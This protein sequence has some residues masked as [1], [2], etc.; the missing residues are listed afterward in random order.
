MTTRRWLVILLFVIVACFLADMIWIGS[1]PH[2]AVN[3]HAPPRKL[4][5]D[6]HG[7]CAW[8]SPDGTENF[9]DPCPVEVNHE[10]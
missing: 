8:Q 1:K 4:W 2:Q 3:Q 5:R 7:G 6:G 10:K 9:S